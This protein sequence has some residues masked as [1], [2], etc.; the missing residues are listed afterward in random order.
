MIASV[1]RKCKHL[2]NPIANFCATP[3]AATRKRLRKPRDGGRLGR[4]GR[5]HTT[6]RRMSAGAPP[7]CRVG[8]PTANQLEG[9]DVRIRIGTA[10]A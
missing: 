4:S 5:G 8:E 6:M 2:R 3:V 9:D 1:A 7:D 10:H